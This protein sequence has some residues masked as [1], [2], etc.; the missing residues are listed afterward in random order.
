[1]RPDTRRRWWRELEIDR[2]LWGHP[3]FRQAPALAQRAWRPEP[4]AITRMLSWAWDAGGEVF[5]KPDWEQRL[6][7]EWRRYIRERGDQGG[8]E[9]QEAYERRVEEDLR[10]AKAALERELGVKGDALCWPENVF[11]E[12]SEKLARRVGYAF[13]VSNRHNSRNVVGETPDRIMRV[14]I[15]SHAL[16]FSSS[17]WEFVCFVLELKV[18]EGWYVAYPLLFLFH[19]AKGTVRMVGRLLFSRGD[20][21]S[22]WSGCGRSEGKKGASRRC[23]TIWPTTTRQRADERK[24]HEG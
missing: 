12:A 19:R 17:L 11:S 10:E 1:M 5:A 4:D 13:T 8:W 14:F 24:Q 15:G 2:S 6:F 20:F 23:G 18:F 16:G 7:E 21:I 9:S 3:V 22:V